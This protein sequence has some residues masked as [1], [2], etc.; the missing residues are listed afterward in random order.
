MRVF[1]D[2]FKDFT[3]RIHKQIEDFRTGL[4]SNNMAII[5]HFAKE[6]HA[7]LASAGPNTATA[8]RICNR[9]CPICGLGLTSHTDIA[10]TIGIEIDIGF[11][12]KLCT[13]LHMNEVF[14]LIQCDCL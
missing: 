11:T 3:L 13:I 7:R 12:D 6:N 10:P 5:A 9:R 14:G 4:T 1:S 8:K 2:I